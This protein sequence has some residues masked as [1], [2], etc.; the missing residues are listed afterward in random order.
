MATDYV[1]LNITLPK[2]IVCIIDQKAGTRK[3]S[4]FIAEAVRLKLQQAQKEALE[5]ELADGYRASFQEDL[6][7]ASEFE[8][9]DLEGWPDYE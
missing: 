8:A 2:D 5:K 6:D 7:L 9:V 3:R 4:Q 1:R